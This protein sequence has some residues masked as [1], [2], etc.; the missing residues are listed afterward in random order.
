M[1]SCGPPFLKNQ[2]RQ[3]RGELSENFMKF[4]NKMNEDTKFISQIGY[5]VLI[6]PNAT[7]EL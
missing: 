7:T 6:R 1:Q 5:M 2:L 3:K 4:M